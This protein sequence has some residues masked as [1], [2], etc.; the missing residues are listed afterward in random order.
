MSD[1]CP[2]PLV[3]TRSRLRFQ[4]D[5]KNFYSPQ[6][7]DLYRG[8]APRLYR[9]VDA[10]I[11]VCFFSAGEILDQTQF[12]TAY[13][14]LRPYSALDV[15]PDSS[16]GAALAVNTTTFTPCTVWE[17][18]K[19]EDA[20]CV[21][22]LTAA[23]TNLTPGDYWL[24]LYVNTTGDFRVN[25]LAGKFLVEETGTG[26]T[27]APPPSVS[28]IPYL[29]DLVLVTG[30]SSGPPVTSLDLLPTIG[31]Y[32]AGDA[33]QFIAPDANTGVT[34]IQTWQLRA[35]TEAT[36]APAGIV[37]AADYSASWQFVWFL[38]GQ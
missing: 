25:F 18:E 9:G 10:E 22:T 14:E 16:V 32:A 8:S 3:L 24:S 17:W 33:V 2:A 5:D 13:F 7:L 11:A 20:H 30:G 12:A 31:E 34:Q 15:P 27:P 26:V 1:L 19:N 23:Q 6:P 36:N 29:F 35:S 28:Y 37:R 38:A 21:F 4:A